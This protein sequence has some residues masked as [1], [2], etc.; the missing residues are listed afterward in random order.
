[1]EDSR[2]KKVGKWL[3]VYLSNGRVGFGAARIQRD[4]TSSEIGRTWRERATERA[5]YTCSIDAW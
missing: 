1:M 5:L 2:E 4:G 3:R